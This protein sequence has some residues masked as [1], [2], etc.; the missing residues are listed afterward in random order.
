MSWTHPAFAAVAEL[1]GKR[2]GLTFANRS[3]KVLVGTRHAAIV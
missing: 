2:T 1:V 3:Q